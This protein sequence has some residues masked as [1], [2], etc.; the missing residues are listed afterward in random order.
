M[1]SF[2]LLLNVILIFLVFYLGCKDDFFGGDKEP[3]KQSGY[4]PPEGCETYNPSEKYGM[5]SFATAQMLAKNYAESEGKRFIYDGTLKTSEQDALNIWFD[6]KI[7]KNFISFIESN[8][9]NAGCDTSVKLGVRIYYGKYPD[10]TQFSFYP[11]LKDVPKRFGKHHTIFMMPTFFDKASGKHLDFDPLQAAGDCNFKPFDNN[12]TTSRYGISIIEPSSFRSPQ[13]SLQ[14]YKQTRQQ[15]NDVKPQDPKT[16]FIF[17]SVRPAMFTSTSA[18]VS[19]E[20][21]NHGDIVPP[22]S[23]QGIYPTT[24]EPN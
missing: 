6:L 17:G 24:A 7:L 3:G 23:G 12:Y 20:Q 1:K 15:S 22:P 21:Q 4:C 11:D 5:I 16:F 8:A 9:C 2:S 19:G 14:Y 10:S 18:V 13:D